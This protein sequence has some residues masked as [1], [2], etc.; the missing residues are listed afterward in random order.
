[1]RPPPVPAERGGRPSGPSSVLGGCWGGRR[2]R[3]PG[4]AGEASL[5]CPSRNGG[6]ERMTRS[7]IPRGFVIQGE[8]LDY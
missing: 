8:K 1:M 6:R 2:Q 3:A 4:Y 5:C 7:F